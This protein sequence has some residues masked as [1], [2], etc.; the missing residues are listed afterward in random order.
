MSIDVV[1]LA[2][3]KAYADELVANG[4]DPEKIE[5]IIRDKI[6]EVLGSVSAGADWAI[7]DE[8]AAGYIKNRTHYENITLIPTKEGWSGP[9]GQEVYGKD[10]FIS[11]GGDDTIIYAYRIS[12]SF[13]DVETMKNIT[14]KDL[15]INYNGKNVTADEVFE[16]E[17][18]EVIPNVLSIISAD[19]VPI[20]VN[21][22]EEFDLSMVEQ[23][24]IAPAG[25][26]FFYSA[27][28]AFNGYLVKVALRE[29]KQLDL[30]YIPEIA[31]GDIEAK[32]YGN[33]VEITVTKRDG[34]TKIVSINDGQNGEPG[35]AGYSPRKGTDYWTAS[36]IAQI[37]SYVDSAILG[38]S[39]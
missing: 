5:Q 3:A 16:I 36:D 24:G 8:T 33:W 12:N 14:A 22:S 23:S 4:G 15:I 2:L 29:T 11:G 34:T 19:G 25:T 28:S 37:K 38:G 39:W 31:F 26:Y 9:T 18:E 6:N 20:L 17:F 27:N 13:L 21:L 30:K 7:N 32:D 35:P 1:T 10:Y